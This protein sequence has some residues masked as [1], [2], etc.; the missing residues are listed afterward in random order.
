MEAGASERQGRGIMCWVGGCRLASPSLPGGTAPAEAPRTGPEPG[1]AGF[2]PEEP[3]RGWCGAVTAPRPPT[4]SPGPTEGDPE[5]R[6]FGGPS[7]K[8]LR[9]GRAQHPGPRMGFSP[10]GFLVRSRVGSLAASQLGGRVGRRGPGGAEP[11][12]L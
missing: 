12:V 9:A 4:G 8:Q 6:G 5:E 3:G 10:L 7:A 2:G 1:P 11:V